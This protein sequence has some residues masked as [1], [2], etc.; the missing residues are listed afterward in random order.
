MK[1]MFNK[2]KEEIKD[3]TDEEEMILAYALFPD[4]TRKYLEDQKDDF[5]Y[6][7]IVM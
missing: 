3:L 6:I 2:V 7:D 4:I 1:P 5:Y